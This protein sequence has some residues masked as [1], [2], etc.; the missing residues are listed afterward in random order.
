MGTMGA[1]CCHIRIGCQGS[2]GAHVCLILTGSPSRHTQEVFVSPCLSQSGE[3]KDLNGCHNQLTFQNVKF[4]C[5]GVQSIFIW[6]TWYFLGRL[7]KK[8]V[9][10][11]YGIICYFEIISWLEHWLN[12]V[13]LDILRLH[14]KSGCTAIVMLPTTSSFNKLSAFP[15]CK[16]AEEQRRQ[17]ITLPHGCLNTALVQRV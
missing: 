12:N 17:Y 3:S 6:H 15:R 9:V 16:V 11:F 7:L 4:K 13:L 5:M 10:Q 1:C 8:D 14:Q 2:D